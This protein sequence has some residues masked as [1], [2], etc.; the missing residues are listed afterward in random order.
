[1]QIQK[2]FSTKGCSR[3]VEV[4][5]HVG[6]KTSVPLPVRIIFIVDNAMGGWQALRVQMTD[7]EA[8]ALGTQLLQASTT[9]RPARQ[10]K[11][12]ESLEKGNGNEQA[13]SGAVG[14]S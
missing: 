5:C 1:M 9:A 12:K 14:V 3:F 6:V 4:G 2:T 8:R 13:H 11:E 10:A 7:A